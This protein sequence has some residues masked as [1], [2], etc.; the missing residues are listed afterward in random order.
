MRIIVSI[1][2]L[3]TI[4]FCLEFNENRNYPY[5]V[6]LPVFLLIFNILGHWAFPKLKRS[7]VYY[8]FY[9][10]AIIRYCLIPLGIALGNPL[11]V[12]QH[13]LNGSTAIF[14][15]GI[16]L[17]AIFM[18]F[19]YQ[20]TK[21]GSQ[22]SPNIILISKNYW[23]YLFAGAMFLIIASSGFLNKVNFLGN[24]ASYVEK[25]EGTGEE[26][27][28]D[29]IGGVLFG[30]FRIIILLIFASFI[31]GAKK[32][33]RFQKLIGLIIL[34]GA[35]SSFIIGASR[36]S[37]LLFILPFYLALNTILDKQSRKFVGIGLLSLMIPVLLF[38]SLAKFTRGDTVATTDSILNT[39][40]L[41]AYFAGVGNVAV[42][43]DTFE[44]QENKTY[45]L[46][47]VNDLFQNIPLLSKITDDTYKTNMA[48]NKEIFGHSLWQTQIVPLNISGLFHFNIY[49]VGFYAVLCLFLAMQLEQKAKREA[50]LPY[51]YAFY[52]LAIALSMVFM[53]NLGSMMA[54]IFR[55][56]IFVYLPFAV[57]RILN[58]TKVVY[59]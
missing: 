21:E 56:F 41:N 3:I 16:E 45:V 30:P 12:G 31:L 34:M 32:L 6:F 38:A 10:Q 29:S 39:S 47:L 9:F 8:S 40:S 55:T 23:I 19:L 20:N 5:V 14:V 27:E 4:G 58:K 28:F 51:K 52:S 18:L 35:M 22:E 46:S 48:F 44:K 7:I 33:G 54:S 53:L 26:V 2:C 57:M 42:G 36:L 25:Y 24:F 43:I 1:I 15:M 13:S 11:G 50:Y 59:H 17:L 49:G 37:I